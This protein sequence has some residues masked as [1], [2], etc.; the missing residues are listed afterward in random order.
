MSVQQGTYG[1]NIDPPSE[2]RNLLPDTRAELLVWIWR[3]LTPTKV[4]VHSSSS[5]GLKHDFVNDA[6]YHVATERVIRS[7]ADS[8]WR[9]DRRR[10]S[11]GSPTSRPGRKPNPS[12]GRCGPRW[13]SA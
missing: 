9:R 10:R 6:V 8:Y 13:A 3:S 12:T 1:R 2:Y 7:V 5:H 4:K 11:G